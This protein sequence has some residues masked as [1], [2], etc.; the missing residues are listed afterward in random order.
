MHTRPS[1]VLASLLV[2]GVVAENAIPLGNILPRVRRQAV[3]VEASVC[4][5]GQYQCINLVGCCPNGYFCGSFNGV[6][7]CCADGTNCN[8]EPTPTG[9]AGALSSAASVVAS[10][11]AG[12]TSSEVGAALTDLAGSLSSAASIIAT[13]GSDAPTA[14]EAGATGVASDLSS[15]ASAIASLGV[16]ATSDIAGAASTLASD[17]S[18]AAS[19]IVSLTDPAASA[20][21]SVTRVIS[22]ISGGVSTVTSVVGDATGTDAATE[23]NGG[24]NETGG[25]AP[26]PTETGG[27]GAPAPAATTTTAAGTHLQPAAMSTMLL[28][29]AFIG[30]AIML[31]G[32]MVGTMI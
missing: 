21:S 5:S 27:N 4:P 7:G 13:L 31:G 17:L 22:T 8:N 1:L 28:L 30:G 25:D 15:A 32:T 2:G 14:T 29:S 18:S 6:N 23:G 12:A 9:A 19:A 20:G 11:G 16:T 3:D 10:I 26:N 24:P